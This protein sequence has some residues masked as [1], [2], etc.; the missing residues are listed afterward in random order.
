MTCR[1]C[2]HANPDDANFC[3][4]CGS[5]LAT[6]VPCPNCGRENPADLR[7]C[8]GCGAPLAGEETAAPASNGGGAGARASNG[9]SADAPADIAGGRY[10]IRG[11]LGEGGR[12]RVYLAHDTSLERDVAIALV[13]TEGLDDAARERVRAEARAMARLGDHPAI[14]TVHDIGDEAGSPTASRRR[15]STRTRRA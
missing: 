1:D 6:D 15:S 9:G 8:P 4:S 2:G 3:G 5:A 13:K 10:V 12:K 11:F 14:V 7:F